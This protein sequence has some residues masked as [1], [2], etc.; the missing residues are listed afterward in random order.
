MGPPG[1]G[2]GGDVRSALM[3]RR[4]VLDAVPPPPP[5]PPSAAAVC[6]HHVPCLGTASEWPGSNAK[7]V[8]GLRGWISPRLQ[9]HGPVSGRKIVVLLFGRVV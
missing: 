1:D 8:S 5:P 3:E 2:L 7:L 9:A 6:C 4:R